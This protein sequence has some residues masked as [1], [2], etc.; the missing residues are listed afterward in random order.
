VTSADGSGVRADSAIR[1][2]AAILWAVS[3]G[4]RSLI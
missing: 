1:L 2:G 4:E 3:A